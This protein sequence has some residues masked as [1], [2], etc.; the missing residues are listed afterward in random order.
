MS[1]EQMTY[2]EINKKT[3]IYSFAMTVYEVCPRDLS[4]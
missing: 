3:D 4:L 1:P 2:G